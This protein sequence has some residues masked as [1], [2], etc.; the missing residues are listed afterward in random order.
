MSF[1]QG[2]QGM[3]ICSIIGHDPIHGD[4]PFGQGKSGT[5]L[6]YC[7]RCHGIIGAWVWYDNNWGYLKR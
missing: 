6:D 7:D 4:A 3:N 1:K 2:A 5:T